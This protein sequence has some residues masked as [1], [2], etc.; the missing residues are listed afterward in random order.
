MAAPQIGLTIIKQME[1]NGRSDEEWSNH[2]LLTGTTPADGTAWLALAN[3]LIA[4]ERLLYSTYVSV[5]R[6]YGY[7][8]WDPT[9]ASVYRHTLDTP[10]TGLLASDGGA[11]PAPGDTAVWTRWNTGR[12]TSNGHPIYLRKYFHGVF[13]K[14]GSWNHPT[15]LW[16]S[17]AATFVS[18]L[19]TGFGSGSHKITDR[20]GVDVVGGAVA[21]YFTTRTLKRRGKRR[22]T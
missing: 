9:A 21:E 16:R 13:I 18:D 10:L 12:Q 20:T 14:S 1:Y 17:N 8:T 3:A 19:Q 11:I 4:K 15:D 5:T 7:N 22:P 2:Y 6:V